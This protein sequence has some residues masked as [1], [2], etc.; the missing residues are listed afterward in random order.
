MPRVSI[1]LPVYN[2]ENYLKECIE[3]TLSQTY[4]DLEF[5]ISD[6]ASTDST[7]DICRAYA[8]LDKRIRYFRNK[9]NLGAALNY[10]RA[11]ELSN[12]EYFKWGAHDDLIA[13]DYL[14]YCVESLDRNPKAVLSF[15]VITYVN[16][17]GAVISCG[18]D[19]LGIR[20]DSPAK[21]LKKFVAFQQGSNDIFWAIFGLIRSSA[22]RTT[23]LFGK[24]VANDQT[25]LMKLLIRGA[26]AEV[27]E[28]LYFRRVHPLASTV[29]LPRASY[30]ERARWYDMSAAPVLVLPNWRL[31]YEDLVAIK[32]TRM[33]AAVKA[34]CYLM[35]IK[36]FTFRWKRLL[37]EM[38]SIPAQIMTG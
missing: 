24:Y 6:N 29:K 22:L 5:I 28:R 15:P 14:R 12:T 36:M 21:R 31:F 20:D 38:K 34:Y 16:E 9:S 17:N 7:E 1:G 27:P 2:G 18:R 37:E 10:N 8:R 32:S 25:L 11:F 3:S 26:F 4:G 30:R 13:P 23:D 35:I 19:G 33:E